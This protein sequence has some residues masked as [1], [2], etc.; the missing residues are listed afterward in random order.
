M[1]IFGNIL[2]YALV[3]T[4]MVVSC[5]PADKARKTDSVVEQI[6]IV[7][8]PN[9]T[10]YA[11]K[12]NGHNYPTFVI[13]TED[14]MGNYINTFYITKSYATGIYNHE[15]KGDTAWSNEAGPSYQPA[16]LPYWTHKKGLINS[17]VLIPDSD[18]PFVDAYSGA[19]PSGSFEIGISSDIKKPYKI[20]LEVNQL[21][22][23]NKFWTNNKY[24]DSEA[25]KHSGQ[26]SVIYSVT[27]DQNDTIFHMNPIGYGDPEGNSG[28]LY[29]D[30]SNITTPLSIFSL[31][32]INTSKK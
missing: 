18:N 16:A 11:E 15:M 12:G 6:S 24:P 21:G 7:D 30:L 20:L 9:L 27:I 2:I 23:W 10:I 29:T 31:I 14:L 25:Y 4:L 17:K 3:F 28:N 8:N 19:T 32:K 1:K 22:D 13:W 26:P 5:K